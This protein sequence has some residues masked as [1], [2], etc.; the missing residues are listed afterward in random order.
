MPTSTLHDAASR[1]AQASPA[2][3]PHPGEGE[4]VTYGPSCAET[5]ACADELDRLLLPD[6]PRP[7]CTPLRG[8][9]EAIAPLPACLRDGRRTLPVSTELA[10]PGEPD[11]ALRAPCSHLVGPAR[12][13]RADGTPAPVMSSVHPGPPGTTAPPRAGGRPSLSLEF[14]GSADSLHHPHQDRQDAAH[15]EF[16]KRDGD[17]GDLPH[18]SVMDT[19]PPYRRLLEGA[20][21]VFGGSLAKEAGFST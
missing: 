6:P 15:V 4:R 16:P 1:R 12:A 17:F 8:T 11:S 18:D 7:L 5:D 10:E 14:A 20:G 3:T 9:S 13:D 21:A 2:A 19:R